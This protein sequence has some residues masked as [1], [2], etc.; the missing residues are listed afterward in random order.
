[1]STARARRADSSR[2]GGIVGHG[3]RG[4]VTT[5]H[6]RL[7]AVWVRRRRRAGLRGSRAGSWLDIGGAGLLLEDGVVAQTVPLRLLAVAARWV[8]FVALVRVS[9][10]DYVQELSE[11]LINFTMS[12]LRAKIN[13]NKNR[14][15]P[16]GFC[17]PAAH[18]PSPT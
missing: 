9:A 11:A 5:C 10:C 18:V 15:C 3:R 12:E 13:K 7:G 6:L 1:M 17:C 14:F 2:E 8:G 4:A 16:F